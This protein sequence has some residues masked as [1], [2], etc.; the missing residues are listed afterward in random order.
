MVTNKQC[1]KK[2]QPISGCV[3]IFVEISVQLQKKIADIEKT[4]ISAANIY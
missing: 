3:K 4:A 2:N 1:I